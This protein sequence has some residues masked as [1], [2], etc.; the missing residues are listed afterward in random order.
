MFELKK[1]VSWK[2]NFTNYFTPFFYF[3]FYGLK[4]PPQKAQRDENCHA[5]KSPTMV[6]PPKFK[7]SSI[8]LAF[9]KFSDFSKF[10]KKINIT[11]KV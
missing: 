2:P 6:S 9:E 5:K 10:F 3:I 1:Q 11:N 7:T 4:N 8:S